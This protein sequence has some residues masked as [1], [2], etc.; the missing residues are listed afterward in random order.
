MVTR[1]PWP[2]CS[3][4]KEAYKIILKRKERVGGGRGGSINVGDLKGRRHL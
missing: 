2:G 3:K 4:S 1:E